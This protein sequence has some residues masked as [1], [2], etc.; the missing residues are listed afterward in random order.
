MTSQ[1]QLIDTAD[2]ASRDYVATSDGKRIVDHENIFT[3]RWIV[4]P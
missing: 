1:A 2:D 4:G 3:S